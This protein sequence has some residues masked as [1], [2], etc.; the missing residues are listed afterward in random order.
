MIFHHLGKPGPRFLPSR[1]LASSSAGDASQ[2]A[3]RDL[4]DESKQFTEILS[5]LQGSYTLPAGH[6]GRQAAPFTEWADGIVPTPCWALCPPPSPHIL[7]SPLCLGQGQLASN[8]CYQTSHN[9]K[10]KKQCLLLIH[11]SRLLAMT[12]LCHVMG[13]EGYFRPQS[14]DAFHTSSLRKDRVSH[15]GVGLHESLPTRRWLQPYI[16]DQGHGVVL[17]Q[18][19]ALDSSFP[20]I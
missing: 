18:T 15:P 1:A 5:S 14:C 16:T 7:V 20:G 6:C 12:T 8:G 4:H 19:L 2:A 11:F 3:S 9:L 13:Q 17:L 10:Q